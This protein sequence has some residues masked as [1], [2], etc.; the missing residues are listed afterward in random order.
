MRSDCDLTAQHAVPRG[1]RSTR[2]TSAAERVPSLTLR[3]TFISGF[4]AETEEEHR[5]LVRTARQ[6][7]FERGGAFAYSVED[8]TPAAELPDQLD[9]DLKGARRDE[10]T[11]LFQDHAQEWAEEQVHTLID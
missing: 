8:G 1:R 2:A 4:P 5:E 7:R 11:A 6:L 10:L 3:T 9:D